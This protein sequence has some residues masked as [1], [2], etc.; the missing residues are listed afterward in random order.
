MKVGGDYDVYPRRNA[1]P[2]AAEE[3]GIDA[4]RLVARVRDLADA[5]PDAFAD[6]AAGVASLDRT[7]PAKLVDLV[8]ERARR[9][10]AVVN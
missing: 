4:D 10:T 9:C 6:A 5:A 2:R 3:L 1:W 8:S 7:M